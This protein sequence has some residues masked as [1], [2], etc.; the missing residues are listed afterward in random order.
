MRTRNPAS[1]A[2]SSPISFNLVQEWGGYITGTVSYLGP[3][4]ATVWGERRNEADDVDS[5]GMRVFLHTQGTPGHILPNWF[6]AQLLP[7]GE[8]M[9]GGT[10]NGDAGGGLG[11]SVTTG[12]AGTFTVATTVP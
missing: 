12:Y 4:T 8:S 6:R 10:V 1:D 7:Y 5:A 9:V 3:T 2:D 11:C